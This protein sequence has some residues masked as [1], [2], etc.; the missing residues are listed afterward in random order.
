MKEFSW[1]L[2][3]PKF[4]FQIQSEVALLL[5]DSLLGK[6]STKSIYTVEKWKQTLKS[7]KNK[8]GNIAF[9]PRNFCK[10]NSLLTLF[11]KRWFKFSFNNLELHEYQ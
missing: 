10:S 3:F 2:K 4:I 1:K 9:E 11:L 8:F 6:Q 5:T 7:V